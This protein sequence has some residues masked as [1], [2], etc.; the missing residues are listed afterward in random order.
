MAVRNWCPH[1]YWN[2]DADWS[3]FTKLIHTAP[4][5]YHPTRGSTGKYVN[6]F[7]L[8]LFWSYYISVGP[9]LEVEV[10][11]QHLEQS[12]WSPADV[13]WG[14][15]KS[16]IFGFRVVSELTPK[17]LLGFITEDILPGMFTAIEQYNMKTLAGSKLFQ[18]TTG[19]PSTI[20][21]Y[22]EAID[23][24]RRCLA[25]RNLSP[26]W[27]E[28][29]AKQRLEITCN[30]LTTARQY[31]NVEWIQERRKSRVYPHL[32]GSFM[33]PQIHNFLEAFRWANEDKVRLPA[34][35]GSEVNKE[36]LKDYRAALNLIV[37]MSLTT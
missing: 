23:F 4:V 7:F 6:G 2:R 30:R 36:I 33:R 14:K 13:N 35:D 24:L 3:E 1:P 8:S 31:A 16:H 25:E 17:R 29:E 20:A 37:M 10:D 21:C 19:G 27:N 34:T 11:D 26:L 32:A 28:W 18:T 22:N 5:G 9:V 12:L 15:N